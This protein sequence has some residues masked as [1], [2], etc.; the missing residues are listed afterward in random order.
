MEAK[1]KESICWK[2]LGLWKAAHMSTR[3]CKKISLFHALQVF[4][5][6]NKYKTYKTCV[7]K[8]RHLPLSEINL[9]QCHGHSLGS[10]TPHITRTSK[11]KHAGCLSLATETL[12]G[13]W[14]QHRVIQFL[15]SCS[16]SKIPGF[17]A[18]CILGLLE[19]FFCRMSF[20]GG[21]L[22]DCE[23][24]I[25]MCHILPKGVPRILL[26]VSSAFCIIISGVQL[27]CA[28]AF[29]DFISIFVKFSNC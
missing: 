27:H 19:L 7:K 12:T 24:L 1:A 29:W 4:A 23:Q 26:K 25:L 3:L 9:W 18:C 21:K 11:E 28:D 20:L 5:P 17:V 14:S 15:I 22:M 6:H 10:C 2:R 13:V 8:R 16:G